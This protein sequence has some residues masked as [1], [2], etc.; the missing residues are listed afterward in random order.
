M[1]QQQTVT[2]SYLSLLRIEPSYKSLAGKKKT[3]SVDTDRAR[4][5]TAT[6]EECNLLTLFSTVRDKRLQFM[7][8][9]EE[10]IHTRL[11]SVKKI[12]CEFLC[13][14]ECE[15]STMNVLLCYS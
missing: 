6:S 12:C 7:R 5:G 13:G 3:L 11:R 2:V 9:E 15:F 4:G 14:E 8:G 10:N 1:E